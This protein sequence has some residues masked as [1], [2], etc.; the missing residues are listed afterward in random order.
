MLSSARDVEEDI[1][2]IKRPV[3]LILC[4]QCEYLVETINGLGNGSCVI[5]RI[6]G[7]L[8]HV[9]KSVPK[10]GLGTRERVKYN[11]RELSK[12]KENEETEIEVCKKR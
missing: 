5:G 1:F 7:G 11:E 12:P 10:A 2:P 6:D 4:R 9:S 8:R 3:V